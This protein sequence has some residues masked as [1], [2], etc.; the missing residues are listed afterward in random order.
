[1]RLNLNALRNGELGSYHHQSMYGYECHRE[2]VNSKTGTDGCVASC[3]LISTRGRM[4]CR[5][6]YSIRR[7]TS[8][9][10]FGILC[11]CASCDVIFGSNRYFGQLE[12]AVC[13]P[14][15]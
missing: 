4:E 11:A 6:P 2:G 8:M 12:E 5:L 7:D 13:C 9:F 1:M 15:L 10:T 3:N 14:E